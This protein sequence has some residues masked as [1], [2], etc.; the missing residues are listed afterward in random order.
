MISPVTAL[1]AVCRAPVHTQVVHAQLGSVE[2]LVTA[3][4]PHL[5]PGQSGH[6][7]SDHSFLVLHAEQRDIILYRPAVL[8]RTNL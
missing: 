5:Q 4:G 7:S 8:R 3:P 2:T 6:R 1:A